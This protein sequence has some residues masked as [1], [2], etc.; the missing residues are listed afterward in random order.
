LR[1]TSPQTQQAIQMLRAMGLTKDQENALFDIAADSFGDMLKG[2][3]GDTKAL[4]ETLARG[5]QDPK[6]ILESMKGTH[7]KRI[8]DLSSQVESFNSMERK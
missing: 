2:T 4:K 8:R 7:R 1:A 6:A 3:N 5:L